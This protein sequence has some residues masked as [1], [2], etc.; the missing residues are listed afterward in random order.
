MTVNTR[1]LLLIAIGVIVLGILLLLIFS[2]K[3]ADR[4]EPEIVSKTTADGILAEFIKVQLFYYGES[5]SLL[6]PVDRELRVPEIREELY[7]KFIELLLA[8]SDGMIVPVPAGVQLRSV[9]YLQKAE[10]LVLD[11]NEHLI[12][13]FPGGTAAELEFIYFIVDNICFN[14][15][16]IKKVKLLSG[17][18]EH[19]TLAGHIEL[20]KAFFPDYSRLKSD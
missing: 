15:K 11:F 3:K 6:Q 16:E 4:R 7:K 1:N 13:A 18:N 20:E 9:Y 19:R 12:G 8:G 5:S 14:F 10:M 17:G 2:G